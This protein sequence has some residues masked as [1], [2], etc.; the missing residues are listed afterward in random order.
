MPYKLQPSGDKYYVVD[1]TGKRYSDK[2]LPKWR[3]KKQMAALWAAE[4]KAADKPMKAGAPASCFLVVEDPEK[5]GTW[6]LQVRDPDGKP[7]HN[8]MGAAWAA[9]HAGFRGNK[10]EGP[11]KA[12]AL[13]KLKKLYESEDMP[14]PSDKSSGLRVF[15]QADGAY[16]WLAISSSA[17]RDR[18]GELI[19]QKALEA[20]CDRCDKKKD[21]GPLRWWHLGGWEAPDGLENWETW[22]ATAGI[23]LGMCDFNMMAGKM[24]I[25]SGTFKNAAIGEAF[26][27]IQDDLELSICFSH[28][29]GEPSKSEK[30][31]NNVH[32]FERSL[33][34]AGWASNLLTKF[35]VS[36]GED[37][38]MDFKAK[39]KA[40]VAIFQDDPAKV[41]EILK[42]AA[43]IQK[44]AETVGLEFKEV[45][46][47]SAVADPPEESAPAGENT[48][49]PQGKE[50]SLDRK[51]QVARDAIL[52]TLN[53]IGTDGM[54]TDANGWP[55]EIYE[56]Y[57]IVNKGQKLYKVP[58]TIGADGKAVLGD[59]VEVEHDWK[60]VEKMIARFEAPS[61]KAGDPPPPAAKPDPEPVEIGDWTPEMLQ[62][63][64]LDCVKPMMDQKKEADEAATQKA[65]KLDT[66]LAETMAAVNNLGEQ[67]KTMNEGMTRQ[68]AA[69]DA[70]LDS[71]PA[72]IKEIQQRRP[73]NSPDNVVE[74]QAAGPTIDP[75]FVSFSR[76]GK[77]A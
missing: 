57:A 63:F 20:D 75:G 46:E 27:N 51:A 45:G 47:A 59:P 4:Q 21:Y 15:K 34:P 18:D 70:L 26:A 11:G 33:M 53:P 44:A 22:R 19:T 73:T 16:R 64:V 74:T 77:N 41:E 61:P 8:L 69:V 40:L 72:G 10:Y 67:I 62:K 28:P 3:A 50:M 71:R 52:A 1:D 35:S 2:P 60:P 17:F 14:L 12:E 68:K 38:T 31:F 48:P 56:S 42:D 43:S 5:V 58:Y 23:D 9:L 37:E 76:G 29:R 54:R 7:N 39:V 13:S 66:A 6:H 65:A 30:L 55:L 36:K 49:E 32:R 24:L 25:E